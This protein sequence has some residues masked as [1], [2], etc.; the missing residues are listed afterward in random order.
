MFMKSPSFN[1]VS[2]L[3]LVTILTVTAVGCAPRASLSPYSKT[4]TVIRHPDKARAL[5]ER[6][7]KISQSDPVEAERL[8]RAAL[9]ADLYHGP[10]HNNLGTLLLARGELYEAAQEFEWARK[11]MPGHPS[12][13]VNLAMTLERAGKV[14]DALK[15]YDAALAVYDHYLP[16]I[17]GKA[18]LQILSGTTDETTLAL[19]DAIALR[20]DPS[21]KNWARLQAI[22]LRAKR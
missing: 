16:A 18:R 6:A 22:K 1:R 2:R 14:D 7:T 10:S 9:A 21:W 5:H 4:N 12:P 20:A 19:L 8:V 11:L 17:E 15:E 3:S 13:R